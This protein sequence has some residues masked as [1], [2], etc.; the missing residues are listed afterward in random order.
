MNKQE[1]RDIELLQRDFSLHVRRKF[2]VANLR[3]LAGEPFYSASPPCRSN[4]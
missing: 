2:N 4:H 1:D 3:S